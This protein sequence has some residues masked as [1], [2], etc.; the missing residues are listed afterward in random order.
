[1]KT[2]LKN[3]LFLTT[4][5]ADMLSNFGD[6]LYYMALMN[7]VL[8][9]PNSQIAISAVTLSETLPMLFSFAIGI[10][11]DQTKDKLKLILA[12]LVLRT[13]LYGILGFFMGFEPQLWIVLAATGINF[14][15]DLAGQY[16]NG[17]YT[18]ISL[19][20]V[21]PEDRQDTAAFRQSV[22]T[23]LRLLFKASGAILIG[24]MSYQQLAFFNATTFAASALIMLAIKP[25][26][27]ALLT[28]DPIKMVDQPQE[29]KNILVDMWESSKLVIQEIKV[30]PVLNTM[31]IIVPIFNAIFSAL[32]VLFLFAASESDDL[33]LVNLPLTLTL[34]SVSA[35]GGQILGG[36]LAMNL[37]KNWDVVKTLRLSMIFPAVMFASFLLK[38]IYLMLV[39]SFLATVIIGTL[40][41]KLQALI[42]NSLPE[43]RLATIGA[44]IDTYFTAGILLVR[45]LLSG[46]I[47]VVAPTPLLVV[48]LVASL[49]LAVYTFFGNS[50]ADK[51]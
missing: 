50:R 34:I 13:V 35:M 31:M 24:L 4:F 19:R 29:K 32:D 48:F 25:K 23:S 22:G 41:P 37:A 26:L 17:L 40:G 38:N 3:K 2:V 47:L 11:A 46:L 49:A 43:E 10:K 33:I 18:P 28:A 21:A 44:G 16:E 51:V 9:L 45:L 12:T 5:V 7:Y 30:I 1:M 20:V 36:F 15:S 42:L 14:V 27:T 6:I 8:L 39:V